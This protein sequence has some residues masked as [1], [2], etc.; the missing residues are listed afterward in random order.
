M[1]KSSYSTIDEPIAL[2]GKIYHESTL[3]KSRPYLMLCLPLSIDDCSYIYKKFSNLL[4]LSIDPNAPLYLGHLA[5][6]AI[7]GEALL[8]ILTSKADLINPSFIHFKNVSYVSGNDKKYEILIHSDQKDQNYKFSCKDSV[9]YDK[10]LYHL[11][12]AHKITNGEAG[13]KLR[14]C[15][16]LFNRETRNNKYIN[17]CDDKISQIINTPNDLKNTKII[18]Y[19]SY[20]IAKATSNLINNTDIE[21]DDISYNDITR[22]NGT[23]IYSLNEKSEDIINDSFNYNYQCCEKY[24]ENYNKEYG[25]ENDIER[26]KEEKVSE[27]KNTKTTRAKH[28]TKPEDEQTILFDTHFKE[29]ENQKKKSQ[30]LIP[31]NVSRKQSHQLIKDNSVLETTSHYLIDNDKAFKNLKGEIL[32]ESNTYAQDNS[33]NINK[34]NSQLNNEVTVLLNTNN[35]SNISNG[36]KIN[37]VNN[38]K[39][40]NS[41]NVINCSSNA[42]NPSINP[43]LNSINDNVYS[44]TQTFQ[45]NISS[46][47]NDL[48]L[49]GTSVNNSASL[50]LSPPST[51]FNFDSSQSQ[52]PVLIPTQIPAPSVPYGLPR[53]QV[54]YTPSSSSS[55][56]SFEDINQVLNSKKTLEI[57][58]PHT[59]S[60][61]P[62]F[63]HPSSSPAVSN[64]FN[65]SHQNLSTPQLSKTVEPSTPNSLPRQQAFYKQATDM[66]TINSVTSSPNFNNNNIS[67]VNAIYSAPNLNQRL[68]VP[69][70]A[71]PSASSPPRRH[72]FTKQASATSTTTISKFN[73]QYEEENKFKSLPKP[74]KS[75]KKKFQSL[76][77]YNSYKVTITRF[78]SIFSNNKNKK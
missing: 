73:S 60:R 39:I 51:K 56:G 41:I 8:I 76:P 40:N 3:L 5:I 58:N 17:T 67:T 75:V 59:L 20:T 54:F 47:S 50:T 62:V 69:E 65:L 9:E 23:P 61:L 44:Y 45:H 1:N 15:S 52:I 34:V 29:N 55:N 7:N 4:K 10:W 11:N 13:R 32:F 16:L 72:T 14:F 38:P 26:E 42:N 53:H 33:S 24:I 22:P 36:N 70:D 43:L 57:S 37:V 27:L 68:N 31:I 63:Y 25:K 49:N 30:S 2:T 35:C 48:T 19:N 71:S 64:P 74:K 12:Q 28:G 46:P 78:K 18:N 6:A 21:N 66:N 77:R